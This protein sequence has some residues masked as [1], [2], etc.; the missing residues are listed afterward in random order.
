MLLYALER[1]S[2]AW[3]SSKFVAVKL[4]GIRSSLVWWYV[5]LVVVPYWVVVV[6]PGL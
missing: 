1:F 6:E 2:D 3:V 5:G 4:G